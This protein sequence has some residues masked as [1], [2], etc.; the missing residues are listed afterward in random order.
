M[1]LTV[2]THLILHLIG[3][4]SLIFRNFQSDSRSLVSKYQIDLENHHWMTL[5]T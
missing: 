2:K 3:N 1:H 4:N 5:Y